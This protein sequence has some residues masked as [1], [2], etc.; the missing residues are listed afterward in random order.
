MTEASTHN[1]IQRCKYDRAQKPQ[2]MFRPANLAS[3]M[4]LVEEGGLGMGA[5]FSSR[6]QPQNNSSLFRYD[7]A[8]ENQELRQ[9]MGELRVL[10]KQVN[11]YAS[12]PPITDDP[13]ADAE[14]LRLQLR[15][16]HAG[17]AKVF[18]KK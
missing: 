4:S 2:E 6:V 3:H 1:S 5:E 15:R 18:V 12:M 10:A 11:E 8:T 17:L 9:A 14:Q 7:L 16:I 13:V